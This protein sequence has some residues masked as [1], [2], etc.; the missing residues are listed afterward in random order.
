M[1]LNLAW[2]GLKIEMSI[3]LASF[4]VSVE[5]VVVLFPSFTVSPSVFSV[6]CAQEKNSKVQRSVQNNFVI[7]N[8]GQYACVQRPGLCVRQ[9]IWKTS[10][11]EL[12]PIKDTTVENIIL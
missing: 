10:S 1:Y 11:P 5:S 7:I 3:S 6:R 2:V 12:K 8:E 9:G 4:T